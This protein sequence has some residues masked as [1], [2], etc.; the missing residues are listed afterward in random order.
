[1]A[2]LSEIYGAVTSLWFGSSLNLSV[3]SS[4][5]AKEALKENDANL[6]NRFRDGLISVIT[7][8]ELFSPRSMR[9]Q[10]W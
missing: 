9:L 4:G 2:E 7:N 3:C 5:L 10:P 8:H 6:E 1:M